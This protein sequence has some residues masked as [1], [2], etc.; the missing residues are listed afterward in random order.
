VVRAVL[1]TF[2]GPSV[3]LVLSPD[4]ALNSGPPESLDAKD[5]TCG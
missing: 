2:N 3:T 1:T 5:D 4:A